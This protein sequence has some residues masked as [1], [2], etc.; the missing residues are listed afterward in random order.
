MAEYHGARTSTPQS[1]GTGRSYS[2]DRDAMC[3][4]GSEHQKS[5]NRITLNHSRLGIG[6]ASLHPDALPRL[7]HRT[8][9]PAVN[10]R[11]TYLSLQ[12]GGHNLNAPLASGATTPHGH[13]LPSYNRIGP[14]VRRQ[15]AVPY[16]KLLPLCIAR[17][18]EGMIGS[19]IFPYINEMILSFGVNE[20]N[21]GVWSAVAVSQMSQG[22]TAHLS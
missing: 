12:D 15:T 22:I 17:I 7:S 6:M 8:P 10:G 11:P 1:S 2:L 20:K 9:S 16:L 14:A 4:H 19:V 13:P 5:Q 3:E 18:A 21:V